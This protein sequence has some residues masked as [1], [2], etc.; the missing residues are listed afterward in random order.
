[1]SLNCLSFLLKHPH[2]V[3]CHP[4]SPYVKVQNAPSNLQADNINPHTIPPHRLSLSDSNRPVPIAPA[5]FGTEMEPQMLRSGYTHTPPDMA[6]PITPMMPNMPQMENFIPMHGTPYD[7][8]GDNHFLAMSSAQTSMIDFDTTNILT[9]FMSPPS[10]MLHDPNDQFLMNGKLSMHTPGPLPLPIQIQDGQTP[11]ALRLDLDSPHIHL[12]YRAPAGLSPS[13]SSASSGLQEPDAVLAAHH[14]WPFFQCNRVEKY[15]FAPPKT[16]AIY[17][18]GLAQTLRNQAT[19]TA[20]TAQLD[21]S[22]LD[23]ATE[24]KIATE[25]IVGWSREKLLAITQGF[26]HKA[27]DIHKAD[28]AAREDTPSSPDSGRDAFL[29][30]PPPDVMQYFLRSYVVRYEPYYS[31]V[32]AG[33]LDP[34]A[35]LQSHNSKAASLLV[36]LMVASGASSTATVEARYIASGLTEACRISLFDTIEKDVLQSREVFILRSALLFT[37]LAAWSGDKWHM[38]MAMGQRGM[39]LAMLAH[40]GM[41]EAADSHVDVEKC[42]QDPEKA[43]E[44]WKEREGKHRYGCPRVRK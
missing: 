38:D 13:S 35:F 42:K 8:D 17:L 23:I 10:A 30:L 40:S 32:P 29:M 28:H 43:W 39:Y 12:Q 1:M 33:R 5:V 9:D 20:W 24:R 7:P 19:W 37:C 11:Y 16:A 14:A 31:S 4:V 34:N 3:V 21:E 26:L 15:S 41:L 22:S 25:P 36:L 2:A 44:E 6:I 18:E 27:L